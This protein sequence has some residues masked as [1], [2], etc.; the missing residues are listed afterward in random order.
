MNIYFYDE[1][2]EISAVVDEISS[3]KHT[4]RFFSGDDFEIVFPETEIT[5]RF[6]KEQSIFEI[7]GSLCGIILKTEKCSDRFG[8]EFIVAFGTSLDGML[9]R[10]LFYSYSNGDSFMEI[11]DKNAGSNAIDYRQFQHSY[12]DFSVDCEPTF[13][14]NVRNK[15]L[16]KFVDINGQFNNFGVFSEII[17]GDS[18]SIRFYGRKSVDRSILQ[19]ENNHLILSD[20]YDFVSEFNYCYNSYPLVNSA[21]AYS[22]YR[23]N[24]NGF[25]QTGNFAHQFPSLDGTSGFALSEGGFYIEADVETITSSAPGATITFTGLN[26]QTMTDYAESIYKYSLYSPTEFIEIGLNCGENYANL[27]SVGDVVTV[28]DSS[29]DI[30][31]HP[32]IFE[33]VHEFSPEKNDYKLV[34]GNPNKSIYIS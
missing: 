30:L 8:A 11:L 23:K 6:V 15:T 34:L 26:G 19:S 32:N 27:F 31:L 28:F 24:V 29:R 25:P 2:L 1:N 10:R 4:K 13:V 3:V 33:I 21:I 22:S 12:F 16:D 17:K 20:K 14:E 18:N 7:R 5:R 9:S